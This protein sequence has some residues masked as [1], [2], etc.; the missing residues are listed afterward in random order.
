MNS[1]IIKELR[2]SEK[3]A[4]TIMK[5][6]DAK[7]SS[8][9]REATASVTT[10]KATAD[11]EWDLKRQKALDSAKEKADNEKVTIMKDAESTSKK[12]KDE[13]SKNMKKAVG[14][15]ESQFMRQI[16]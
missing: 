3:E 4:E 13:A 15:V 9:L 14:Y 10:M 12:I 16:A 5:T 1:T 7:K 8:I 2:D 6:G 11:H